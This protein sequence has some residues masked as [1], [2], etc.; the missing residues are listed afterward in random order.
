[1]SCITIDSGAHRMTDP[2]KD[3][4]ERPGI[5]ARLLRGVLSLVAACRS[6]AALAMM[7]ERDLADVGLLP[8][9]VGSEIESR[10]SPPSAKVPCT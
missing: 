6:G 2:R 7:S 5:V 1:M 4:E 9:E 3:G 8:W 10:P